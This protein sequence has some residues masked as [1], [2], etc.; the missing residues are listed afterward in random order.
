MT[1]D[2][3]YAII[4]TVKGYKTSEKEIFQKVKKPIDRTE[5]IGYTLDKV[6]NKYQLKE[7]RLS[8]MTK[9]EKHELCKIAN[10]VNCY[11]KEMAL[12]RKIQSLDW[13]EKVK[14]YGSIDKAWDNAEVMEKIAM[15]TFHKALN[16]A[17]TKVDMEVY[18]VVVKTNFVDKCIKAW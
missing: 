13:E 12:V 6:L 1:S 5:K 14:R 7:K 10:L 11:K 3:I 2:E 4:K 16:K 8:I 18:M 17:Y 15:H 9:H